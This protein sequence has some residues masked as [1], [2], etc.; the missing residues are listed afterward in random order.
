MNGQEAPK[1]R[2]LRIGVSACLLGEAVRFNGGHCA[3]GLLLREAA[4]FAEFVSVCPE[5]AIGLGTPRETLRLQRSGDL[6][7]LHAPESGIDHTGRMTAYS[8]NRIQE[9]KRSGLDGFVLKKD[10]PSCGMQRVKVYDENGSPSKVGVGVF[11]EALLQEWP[12]LPVEEE[13]R[14]NDHRLRENF[15][16]RVFAYRRLQDFFSG[17]W[18]PASLIRFHTAEKLLL[19]SHDPEGIKQLGRLVSDIRHEDRDVVAQR[20]MAPF[21]RALSK[22]ASVKRQTA[23]LERILGYFKRE[24]DAQEK[25]ELLTVM[26]D[27]RRGLAPLIAPLTLVRHYV[28]KF[29]VGYIAGQT[30]LDPHPKELMLRARI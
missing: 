4:A 3:N 29:G 27:F 20:Y 22:P 11:A 21:M 1:G 2:K 7:M 25:R 15:F 24:L 28:R 30:Y 14:L 17:D 26:Q 12:L 16:E 19:L 18:T 10:S 13:G 23:V 5:V 9:L 8:R 6:V